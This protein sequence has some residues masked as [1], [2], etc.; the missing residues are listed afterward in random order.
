MSC[1]TVIQS[2]TPASWPVSDRNSSK[3]LMTRG[4]GMFHHLQIGV[5]IL[6]RGEKLAISTRRGFLVALELV[7]LRDAVQRMTAGRPRDHLILKSFPRLNP[8]VGANISIAEALQ[9][10]PRILRRLAVTDRL[11]LVD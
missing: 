4:L 1:V 3:P 9:L 5:G 2:L 11:F 10:R 8:L 7:R 6:P